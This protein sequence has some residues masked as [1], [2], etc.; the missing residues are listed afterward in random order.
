MEI[1]GEGVCEMGFRGDK[2]PGVRLNSLT[3]MV[4]G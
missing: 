2:R 3:S 4:T 1:R